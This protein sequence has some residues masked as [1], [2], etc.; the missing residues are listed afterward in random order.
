MKVYYGVRGIRVCDASTF[1]CVTSAHTMAPV[2]AVA[3]GYTDLIKT[4]I[5]RTR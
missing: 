1:P 5:D 3:E 2:I 4:S